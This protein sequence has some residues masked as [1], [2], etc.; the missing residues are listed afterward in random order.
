[1]GRPLCPRPL[2]LTVFR[3]IQFNVLCLAFWDRFTISCS[4]A[5]ECGFF[6][7]N[8]RCFL[9]SLFPAPPA[10]FQPL[11]PRAQG[12]EEAHMLEFHNFNRF[13][14]EKIDT[15]EEHQLDCEA[16]MLVFLHQPS[17]IPPSLLWELLSLHQHCLVPKPSEWQAW[18]PAQQ[19]EGG[20][21]GGPEFGFNNQP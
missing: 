12:L 11:P 7:R 16:A 19:Q 9:G 10:L 17:T 6:R 14:N 8:I 1:M 4:Q 18:Y 15:L 21:S 3:I 20:N 2:L 13:W 5:E